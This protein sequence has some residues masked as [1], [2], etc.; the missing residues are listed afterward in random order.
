[1]TPN[2]TYSLD[3]GNGTGVTF[4]VIKGSVHVSAY[5]E[6]ADPDAGSEVLTLQE[7][8]AAYRKL[9]RSGYIAN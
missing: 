4:E 8:R 5:G 1:M 9:L 2:S 3:D 7:A 6:G